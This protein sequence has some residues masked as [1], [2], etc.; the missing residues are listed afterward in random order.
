VKRATADECIGQQWG[1]DMRVD[2]RLMS[3]SEHPTSLC[4]AHCFLS[5]HDHL[6]KTEATLAA[7]INRLVL[8]LAARVKLADPIAASSLVTNPSKPTPP[9]PE[10]ASAVDHHY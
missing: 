1:L 6:Q 9:S 3:T 7:P 2:G 10:G 4:D 5:F 8:E